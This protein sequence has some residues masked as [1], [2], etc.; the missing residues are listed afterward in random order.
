MI[1]LQT[2]RLIL[3][4]WQDSDIEPFSAMNQDPEVMKFFPSLLTP[5][6]SLGLI[7]RQRRHF[8]DHGFCCYAVELKSSGEFIGFVG[9]AIPLFEA[10]FMPAVEVGWRIARSHWNKGYATEAAKY[11]LNLAFNDLNLQEVV[12][13]TAVPNK[14]SQR[15]MEK[16]GMTHDP[17]DD[18]DHPK[19]AEGHLLRK[20]VLY[21]ITADQI[22][23][24]DSIEIEAADPTWPIQAQEEIS[25]ISKKIAFLK[26][27]WFVGIQHMGSTAIP[28]LSAKPILDLL[29]GVKDLTA[30]KEALVPL[31][32]EEGY[33][34]WEANPD[35]SKLFFA[36]GMP[37]IGEKRSHH[38]HVMEVTHHDWIVRPL[39]R[40]YLITHPEDKKAYQA[41]KQN[42]S[43]EFKEDREAYTQSK[44]N[45]IQGINQKAVLPFLSFVPL[46]HSHFPLLLNWFNQPHVQEFYSLRAWTL[47]EIEEKF[48]DRITAGQ[49]SS[50]IHGF[51][52]CI[53]D[54]PMAY[55]QCYP[56]KDHPW[57]GQNF[58]EN[59]IE[60]AVGLDFFMGEPSF[61]GKKMAAP[62]LE[63]FIQTEIL[64]I[65][66]DC[67]SL[68]VDPEIDN[69]R[70]IAFEKQEFKFHQAIEAKDALGQ[71]KN[72]QLMAKKVH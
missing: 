65:Y 35:K 23:A 38:I 40:D 37:P 14:T 16:I 52:A 54:S 61:L 10:P 72:Y 51:L 69:Q 8:Q 60:K 9:L 68:V 18:F 43:Q 50:N 45:F 56:V 28:E 11:V 29:I 70:S 71:Q 24:K 4:T 66:P 25:R 7:E 53:K 13:F 55:L 57:V 30:A 46:D 15:V 21:R 36:K 20:H 44:T 64:R 17:I 59:F 12:S 22:K 5:E 41:L 32:M 63:K 42:L 58:S 19:L 1:I 27:S 3:R 62:V 67:E 47:S 26:S 49:N 48:K 33:V 2:P 39:F 6:Q 31:L 34:F